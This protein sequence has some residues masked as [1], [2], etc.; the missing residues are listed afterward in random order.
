M[1]RESTGFR[2]PYGLVLLIA[3]CVFF[4]EASVMI[5]LSLFSGISIMVEALFDA[6]LLILILSPALYI[7][8]F[9]PFAQYVV[10]L[11]RAQH[12]IL[13]ANHELEN[14]VKKRT[15]EL[16]SRTHQLNEQVKQMHC[17]Y[18][19]ASL[20]EDYRDSPEKIFQ[21]TLDL[22]P[23]AWHHPEITCAR[24]SLKNCEY[25]TENFRETGWKKSAD[26]IAQ[27]ER[28]G[29]LEI[30][31]LEKPPEINEAP[32]LNENRNLMNT[33]A[34]VMGRLLERI[35]AEE[36]LKWD[37]ELN[38]AL[39]ELY[40]PLISPSASIE[41]ISC[42]VL[43]K[44]K[45]LT[46]S[47]H[48]FVSSVDPVTGDTVSHTLTQMLKNECSVASD[49]GIIFPIGADGRYPSLWGHA[50]NTGESFFTNAAKNHQASTGVPDGHIPIQRFL[51]VPVMLGNEL[52]GQIALANKAEDYTEKDLKAISRVAEFYALAIQRNRTEEFLQNAKDELEVRVEA[53]TAE[54]QQANEKLTAEIE[55]RIRFEE[56]LEHSKS[57]LQAVVD[58]ISDPLV[59]IGNDMK[60]KMLNRAAATYYGVSGYTQL[61]GLSCHQALREKFAPC[62]GCEVPAAISGGKSTVFERKGFTEPERLERIFVYPV[63]GKYGGE[64]D[65]LLRISDITEQRL[66]EKQIV[67]SEKM[68][69]LGVMVSSIAHEI[70]NPVNFISFNIPILRDYVNDLLPIVDAHAGEQPDFEIGHLPYPDFREDIFKLL[71]NIEH[72]S[73]RITGFISNL[74]DFSQ[75]KD[76]VE[77]D[78]VDLNRVIGKTLSICGVQLK[79]SVK[80]LITKIPDNLPRIWTDPNALE[81][82]L[83]NLLANAAQAAEKEDSRIELNV[84]I[85]D[86]WLDHL[87]FEVRDNGS[88]MDQKTMQ[89][90]FDPFFTTKSDAGGTGLGLYVTHSLVESLRGRIEVESQAGKGSTFRVV[91]PDRER[92][93]HPRS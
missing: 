37:S 62:E 53:R 63:K 54:L 17:L 30:F 40:A 23:P 70:N 35:Q 25:K 13:E 75:V 39:S 55:E 38:A 48:G 9:R 69:S 88:G 20:I 92:R 72:G 32:L 49:K 83:L 14:R 34:L 74:K 66:F 50:L 6:T 91:L 24:I 41:V 73:G 29:S 90:I 8:V 85:N 10:D 65:V 87:I 76:K 84:E 22:I 43:E 12:V 56:Q 59:L 77:E 78:W 19:V 18:G 31:Y 64:G 67:Q 3:A 79:K 52:V 71:D 46:K 7:L 2:S 51:S 5:V 26:I 80:S 45:S 36:K 15:S 82:I 81:Q 58:G 47:E 60:I 4:A 42:T 86:G 33:I 21:G 61:I 16:Q 93:N 89:K 27:G 28:V 68:A 44:A 57:M 11:K 1:L